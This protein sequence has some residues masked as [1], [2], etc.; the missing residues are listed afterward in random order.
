MSNNLTG[1]RE[2]SGDFF[3]VK[4]WAKLLLLLALPLLHGCSYYTLSDD[5]QINHQALM[6]SPPGSLAVMPVKNDTKYDILSDLTRRELY[7]TLATLHYE[8]VE[9]DEVNRVVAERALE[10]GI[11]ARS[12]PPEAFLKG[13]P[14]DAL[15]FVRVEKVSK[16]W[17]I[18]YSH[19]KLRISMDLIDSRSGD[20]LYKNTATLH[21]RRI[22]IP[23]SVGGIIETFVVTLWNLRGNEIETAMENFG[24]RIVTEFPDPGRSSP[25]SLGIDRI[26][27]YS[28]EERLRAGDDL[29]VEMRGTSGQ[30]ATFDIGNLV[31]G[32]AMR[33]STPGV[34]IGSYTCAN[35]DLSDSGIVRV[36]LEMAS[37][38]KIEKVYLDGKFRIDALPPPRPEIQRI[39]YLD[40]ALRLYLGLPRE[41]KL[42]QFEIY[43]SENPSD[44]YELQGR[45]KD[46]TWVDTHIKPNRRYSYMVKA[47]DD[48]NNVSLVSPTRDALTPDRGPTLLPKTLYGKRVLHL[49]SSP[50]IISETCTLDPSATLRVEPGVKIQVK[51]GASLVLNGTASFDGREGAMIEIVGDGDAD[52]IVF[53]PKSPNQTLRMHYTDLSKGATGIRTDGGKLRIERCNFESLD[54]GLQ[55]V[56]S[57]NL[58]VS[59]SKFKSV[60]RAIDGSSSQARIEYSEFVDTDRAISLYCPQMTITNCDFS[61]D[62]LAIEQR[63]AVTTSVDNNFFDTTSVAVLLK[64]IQGPCV[65]QRLYQSRSAQKNL[66]SP[67]SSTHDDYKSKGDRFYSEK[68]YHLAMKSYLNAWWLRKDRAVGMRLVDLLKSGPKLSNFLARDKQ[69][70]KLFRGDKQVE[71][72][73]LV[74]RCLAILAPEDVEVQL[75][76]AELLD[77]MGF[78][79]EAHEIRKRMGVQKPISPIPEITQGIEKVRESVRELIIP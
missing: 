20:N 74:A 51:T 63:A 60:Q 61:G 24:Q 36:H 23:T 58:F 3:F 29:V 59:R 22:S 40:D 26:F 54:R 21:K 34:Y 47:V 27:V 75:Q 39:Q 6:A 46:R 35:G 52:L 50:Y 18:L 31:S 57:E 9:I 4:H 68:A 17:L 37:G 45:T 78:N 8:D 69:L 48:E 73:M 67:F 32:L 49:Y 28:E 15:L 10:F 25:T 77:K 43:R 79:P 62:G 1:R 19:I 76:Y 5:P 14:A 16:F 13:K 70:G 56:R 11:P 12:L 2:D 65:F 41:A 38:E 71:S 42:L 53:S 66:F 30:T 55:V 7:S 33:E 44:G 72:A 64:R